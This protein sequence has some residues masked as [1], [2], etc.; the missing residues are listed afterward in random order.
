MPDIKSTLI[1]GAK[2]SDKTLL[3]AQ[4][5]LGLAP[6]QSMEF[7]VFE[8]E[9]DHDTYYCCWSGGYLEKG[10]PYMTPIGQAAFEALADLPMGVQKK[11]IIQE[12]RLGETP[13]EDKIKFALTRAPVGSKICFFGDMAGELD[14]HMSPIFNL[15]PKPKNIAH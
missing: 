15:Q 4:K 5:A 3:K 12:L 11:V 8:V 10:E 9:Y 13:L 7:M 2:P 1:I 14:G 6:D